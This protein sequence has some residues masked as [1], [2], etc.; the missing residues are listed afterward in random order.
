MVQDATSTRPRTWPRRRWLTAIGCAAAL[1]AAAPAGASAATT[2]LAHSK[3]NGLA[4]STG[5][6][7][8]TSDS[9]A[10]RVQPSGAI[11]V[12]YTGHV[13]RASKSNVPGHEI[14]LYSEAHDYPVDFQ[15]ITWAL[16]GG[17]YYGYFV[18]NYKSLGIS[19]I[20]RVSL[21]GGAAT[22]LVT[23]PAAIGARD[24]VNDGSYL[25]WADAGGIR[26]MPIGG[27]PVTTL[28]AGT[29]FSH[30]GLDATRVFYASGASIMTVA[31]AG[32]TPSVFVTASSAIRAMYVLPQN[33]N[34][35]VYWGEANGAVHSYPSYV[36]TYQAPAPG[37]SI[38]SVSVGTTNSFGSWVMWGQCVSG[39]CGVL[40]RNPISGSE[41]TWATTGTPTGLSIDDGGVYWGDN[42]LE[43]N[44][45]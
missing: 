27:G 44:P 42:F 29:T 6:L 20:K 12:V 36:T 5:N 31:K 25:Y 34:T 32:G 11:T 30:V 41:M 28:V 13:W 1:A 26:K 39:S 2:Q 40:M 8:W 22:T 43:K 33:P 21:A 35:Q 18:A 16:V 14:Q 37:V 38:S 3:P 7:Y 45:F 9:T 4:P 24:L 23:S 19:Q 10:Y 15:S 17:Q